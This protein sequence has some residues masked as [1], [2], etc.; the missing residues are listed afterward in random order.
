MTNSPVSEV[1]QG[2]MLVTAARLTS[3]LNRA[4]TLVKSVVRAMWLCSTGQISR[5]ANDTLQLL[6][7]LNQDIPENISHASGGAT[8]GPNTSTAGIVVKLTC[9][10]L[11]SSQIGD[12]GVSCQ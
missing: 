12:G 5:P 7:R 3:L 9:A 1:I 2:T 6:V 11:L 8:P 4:L 10:W